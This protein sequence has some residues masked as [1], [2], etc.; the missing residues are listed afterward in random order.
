MT[1]LTTTTPAKI[2]FQINKQLGAVN[3]FL[4]EDFYHLYISTGD[5]LKL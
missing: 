1:T 2:Y 4:E 3:V 5:I